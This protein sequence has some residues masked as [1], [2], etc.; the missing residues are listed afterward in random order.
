MLFLHDASDEAEQIIN[1]MRNSG[2]ATRAQLV[3][4][5]VELSKSLTHQP[6][7]VLI[8]D[9]ES[10]AVAS[11]SLMEIIKKLGKDIPV[12]FLTDEVNDD[13]RLECLKKG[14]S[15]I[16]QLES[17]EL[18]LMSLDR[19]LEALG[20]R[21]QLRKSDMALIEAEK[22][23][24]TLL[25]SSRDAV[26][27]VA[28]GMHIYANAPYLEIFG[29]TETDEIDCL[30][31]L[32]LVASKDHEKFKAFLKEYSAESSETDT[33]QVTG[34]AADSSE[35]ILRL[36]FS[37]ATYDREACT[38]IIV[39][40]DNEDAELQEKLK[41][42]SHQDLLTG[43][44]NR[45]F[46]LE[47]L[48]KSVQRSL[49]R[50]QNYML[51]FIRLND[52]DKL[53]MDIGIGGIDLIVGDLAKLISEVSPDNS[54][55]AR[56]S[57][58]VFTLIIQEDSPEEAVKFGQVICQKIEDHLPEVQDK[59]VQ[60]SVRVGIVAINDASSNPQNMIMRAHSASDRVKKESKD[61]G[62]GVFL[63]T[64]IEE[65]EDKGEPQ[66]IIQLQKAIEGGLFKILF[67]PIIC[68]RGNNQ[69]FYEV[70]LR[71]LNE[72]GKEISPH[73]FL[74]TAVAYRLSEKIDRWVIIQ[75]IK[76]LTE[77][78]KKGLT[79]RIIINLTPQTLLDETFISWLG[80]V[81]KAS[82]LPHDAMVFQLTESDA[83]SYLKQAKE[84][85]KA[86]SELKCKVAL[87]R[88]GCA[89]NPFSVLKHLTVD[90]LK[91][92]GSYTK[93]LNKEEN[94]ATLKS[95]VETAR[96][97]GKMTI[98]SF[99]EEVTVISSLYTLGM[100]FIQGYYLQPPSEAMD[101]E[102]DADDEEDVG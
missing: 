92:D 91:L 53:I 46:F 16:V 24:G 93:D 8:A 90:Y 31:V 95:I 7:D 85:T 101:Y 39:R 34:V 56:F 57:D 97:H 15:N 94:M 64:H 19:E 4:N 51:Y 88:F 79:T 29:Y 66:S 22:R 13:K 1:A 40:A 10:G 47:E 89:P 12:I 42:I 68:L 21:R 59:T 73:E 63:Y 99:V 102:F 74:K 98:A 32:D 75:S 36:T 58:D 27:Y 52:H 72:E 45:N 35:K 54:I 76:E 23:C 6:W 44:Y 33:I 2:K 9:Y 14:G 80:M 41:S 37:D 26:A 17:Q 86:L 3:H 20:N 38:Q 81:L 67:Q 65:L 82:R 77:S 49:N 60:I 71:M 84:A 61:S 30:P 55:L 96:R 87:S 50:E 78:Y 5:E 69:P 83:H 70:L 25:E 100:N 18:L 43:V 48:E 28:G 62:S 11:D